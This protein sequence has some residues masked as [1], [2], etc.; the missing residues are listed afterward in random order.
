MAAAFKDG[1][2][3]S[4]EPYLS[5]HIPFP[6][7][8]QSDTSLKLLLSQQPLLLYLLLLVHNPLGDLPMLLCSHHRLLLLLACPLPYVQSLHHRPLRWWCSA[9]HTPSLLQVSS[10]SSLLGRRMKY[11]FHSHACSACDCWWGSSSSSTSSCSEYPTS[12]L[13]PTP[14]RF[15]LPHHSL[16]YN[17]VIRAQRFRRQR[18]IL[19]REM[20]RSML[21]RVSIVLI[22]SVWSK[23]LGLM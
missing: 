8:L 23:R 2:P 16:S 13:H 5:P 11:R 19:I 15:V 14:G 1:L 7:L 12:D 9:K 3:T 4:Y 21:K 17:F 10:W 20:M 22:R 6:W 18:R